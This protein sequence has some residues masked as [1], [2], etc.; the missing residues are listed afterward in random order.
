VANLTLGQLGLRYH[1]LKLL[2][3]DWEHVVELVAVHDLDLTL[4]P[5][6]MTSSGGFPKLIPLVPKKIDLRNVNVHLADPTSGFDLENLNLL[7][8]AKQPGYL[9]I[10][11]IRVPNAVDWQGID[12]GLNRKGDHIL[13][14]H[15]Q[16]PPYL[17]LASAD[18]D[19]TGATRGR[20]DLTL[21]GETFGAG[22]RGNVGLQQ[23]GSS[24]TADLHFLLDRLDLA[25]IQTQLPLKG[26]IENVKLDL[27]GDIA[28]PESFAGLVAVAASGLQYQGKVIGVLDLQ[29][30][31][32]QGRGTID[33]GWIGT[34]PNRLTL[35]GTYKLPTSLN[36]P[37][38]GLV[39]D[40]GI[41]GW[42]TRPDN[43]V[44]DVRGFALLRASVHLASGMASLHLETK[45]AGISSQGATLED[46]QIQ[47]LGSALVP[48]GPDL[49]E[50]V[51]LGALVSAR[52]LRWDTWHLDRLGLT[53]GLAEN[54]QLKIHTDLSSG[55]T[56][57][58]AD[59]QA[60]VPNPGQELNLKT[61]EAH[62]KY[63]LDQLS[64]LTDQTL[65][66]G[67]VTGDGDVDLIDTHSQGRLNLQAKDL[68]TNGI[69]VPS[70]NLDAE[71]RDQDARLKQLRVDLDPN[72]YLNLTGS[73]VIEQSLPFQ[74]QGLVALGDLQGL[75][76]FLSAQKLPADL[77]GQLSLK[78]QASGDAKPEDLR[79]TISGGG[80]KIAYQGLVV[81]DFKI[82]ANVVNQVF[83]VQNCLLRLDDRNEIDVGGQF[84]LR[85]PYPFTS[86][87]H[88][89]LTDLS[90]LRP[91]L[92]ANKQP[93][94]LT[95]QLTGDFAL[96][97]DSV[98][99]LQEGSLSA[100][101]AQIAYRGLKLASLDA[102]AAADSKA[103]T[104]KSLDVVLDPQNEIT[105]SGTYSLATPNPYHV[106][107]VIDLRDLRSFD[108]LAKST[109]KELNLFGRLN[110]R[111]TADGRL[112]QNLPEV[113]FAV[114]GAKITAANLVIQTLEASGSLRED[115]FDLPSLR[116]ILDSQNLVDLRAH[117]K[118]A[119]PYPFSAD[120]KLN[121]QNLVIFNPLLKVFGLD[122]GLAGQIN[123]TGSGTGDLLHPQGSFE[124][125]GDQLA[126]KGVQN[127]KL[128]I[129]GSAQ[130]SQVDL[131]QIEVRSPLANVSATL[132][133][134]SD[135]VEIPS[136]RVEQ[137]GNVI[138]GNL[139]VP[140]NLQPGAKFPVALDRPLTFKLDAPKISL[141]S[142]QPDKPQVTGNVALNV[143]A[144]GTLGNPEATLK[145]DLTDFR[146]VAAASVG[147]ASSH[148]QIELKEKLLVLSGNVTQRDIRPLQIKGQL[149]LDVEKVL[150]TGTIDPQT[151]LQFS[152]NLPETD[153]GFVRWLSPLIRLVQ[154]RAAMDATLGGTI[155]KPVVGGQ[156]RAN[157]SQLKAASD[158]IPPLSDFRAQIDFKENRIELTQ[159][160]GLVAGGPL[161]AGGNI[162]LTKLTDPQF[163]L[164]ARGQQILL[165]RSD[166]VIVRSNFDLGVRGPLSAAEVGGTIGITHSRFFQDIDIL[167]LNL[168]GRP[169][170]QPPSIPPDVSIQT[171]PLSN[172]KFNVAIRTADPFL[173]QSN[174]ARGRVVINLHVGGTGAKPE[175]TGFVRIENL[176][177]SLPFSH[178]T[179]ENSYVN[180]VAGRNPLDPNLNILGHSSVR[181]YE[182]RMLIYGR[183]S[184][185]QIVFQSTPPLPQGDI[186]TL[187]A[188]GSTPAEF[189]Q[190]PSLIAG[191][192]AFLVITRLL[193]K[194]FKTNPT[195]Q[196]RSYLDRLQVDIIP[197]STVGSQDVRAR[198]SLTDRWQIIGEFGSE[199]NVGGRLRYLVRFR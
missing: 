84:D 189:V 23:T 15:L 59:A 19:L 73:L 6:S 177:G 120:C 26:I 2:Q 108:A 56:N 143:T 123:L 90:F 142:F 107:S 137:K 87:G 111:L 166:N 49:V 16:L 164:T 4:R 145:L 37:L 160:R 131:R 102:E 135:L 14:S 82:D 33:R 122:L 70:I 3:Q 175:V 57:L 140:L 103:A 196:Q 89:A 97:G 9:R 152:V 63:H 126:A 192:A 155:A 185:F 40:I 194:I 64:D 113:T 62:L 138:N 46:A 27:S 77:S 5:E 167:P 91:F 88:L 32:Q 118:L 117:A 150:T 115:E 94:D 104:L 105:A 101:G 154:G 133:A 183:V 21:L 51:A 54:G 52:A 125:H 45:A 41:A 179:I 55:R 24:N 109:G 18:I 83:Q 171:P 180:F 86:K 187:L 121:F 12:A 25:K 72:N 22:L 20:F 141:A 50:D 44:P 61:V 106:E 85:A 139:K 184:N 158:V 193:G 198:F 172:W 48:L 69:T 147:A 71:F 148:L 13:L 74:L 39:A 42:L 170:P 75:N 136:L 132:T 190:N 35:A 174:L 186:A 81:R 176:V 195:E 146:S 112:D 116:M 151:P 38:T 161:S 149:P 98:T 169:P 124:L 11:R 68:G 130:N 10:G 47:L 110:V 67:R 162:D 93:G 17:N 95:G 128:D 29:T 65:I 43:F 153:L 168:P 76:H 92:E 36:D 129:L 28:Q 197:G 1:P 7:L 53:A 79:A 182:I 181:D 134:T 127:V 165:T 99:P 119:D 156:F 144:G 188:T 34:L 114:G 157:I 100:R 66:S 173:I 80:S 178:M 58:R 8:D 199:G 60:I 191:R 96:H 163:N 31:L 30:T 159:I 78:L